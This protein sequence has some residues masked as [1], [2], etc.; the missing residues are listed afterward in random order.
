[1]VIQVN[2]N[3]ELFRRSSLLYGHFLEH[4]H[5][6]IYGGV[7]DPNSTLSDSDGFRMDVI[8]ALRAIKV[9]V[10]RWPGGCF[11]SSYHWQKGVGRNRVP[12]FDKAWRVEDDNSF[13]TDEFIK[14][15]RKLGCEPY[16]CLNAGTGDLNEMSNWVEYCNLDHEGEYA[17]Q[18]I[19]NGNRHPHKVKYWSIGNE[20]YG[21][22]ELGAKKAEEWSHLVTEAAKL[23]SHVDPDAQLSAAA[24]DDV[25]WNVKLLSQAG[26]RLQ[27]ISIHSYWDGL[28]QVDEPATYEEVCAMTNHTNDSLKR[29]RGLLEAMSFEK[30]IKIAYDEWNLRGWHHPNA[31]TVKQGGTKEDYLRPRDRNDI[32]SVYTMA[33]AVFSACFLNT[34]LRNADVVGMANFAPIVNTRGALFVHNEGIVKRTTYHVFDLYANRMGDIVLDGWVSNMESFDC[35]SKDGKTIERVPCMDVMPTRDSLTGCICLSVVNKHPSMSKD[36]TIMVPPGKV[37]AFTLA[38]DSKDAYNDIECTRAFIEEDILDIQYSENRL[39][40]TLPPHSVNVLQIDSVH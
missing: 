39:T 34:L 25:N 28:W 11:A 30:T 35:L 24:L 8:K 13:G 29:V 26:E 4:F 37:K 9:P 36:L 33:D 15:C 7:F 16:I 12:V 22:W 10:I 19:Q 14:F 27:W 32:N 6:Q 3:R 5:R 18:R 20:N 38:G 2:H 40:V 21:S 31:H 23:I 1:M 17:K